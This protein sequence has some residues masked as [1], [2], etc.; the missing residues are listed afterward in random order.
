[1]N[2]ITASWRDSLGEYS[3]LNQFNQFPIELIK[4]NDEDVDTDKSISLTVLTG[5]KGGLAKKSGTDKWYLL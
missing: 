3:V 2:A 5:D 1:M 4:E